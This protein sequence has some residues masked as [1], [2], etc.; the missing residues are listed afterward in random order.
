[1]TH[2]LFMLT[3][4]SHRRLTSR[5]SLTATAT[6]PAVHLVLAYNNLL[7]LGQGYTLESSAASTAPKPPVMARSLTISHIY[8]I[9]D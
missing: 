7:L 4:R 8:K 1:M 9:P 5:P 2:M 3:I 6:R